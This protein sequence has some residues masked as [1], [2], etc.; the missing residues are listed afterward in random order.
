MNIYRIIT[1][2]NVRGISPE[3]KFVNEDRR[4]IINTTPEAPINA[5]LNNSMFKTPVTRAVVTIMIK[6]DLEP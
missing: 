1:R 2:I 4:I 6:S 3:L 5:L